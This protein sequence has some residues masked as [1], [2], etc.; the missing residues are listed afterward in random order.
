VSRLADIQ[1]AFQRFLLTSDPEIG[2]HVVG[3]ERVP[4]EVRLGIY[5]DGYR[6]RL[7]EV[8]ESSYPWARN[9]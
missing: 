3:T 6:S 7:I 4:V 8:L 5:G 1:E 9:T 2:S